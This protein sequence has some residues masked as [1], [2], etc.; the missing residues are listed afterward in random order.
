MAIVL[1]NYTSCF[2][3]VRKNTKTNRK[4]QPTQIIT[5]RKT[6]SKTQRATCLPISSIARRG[7][8]RGLRRKEAMSVECHQHCAG[9]CDTC[10]LQL[11]EFLLHSTKIPPL[12]A[13]IDA[14]IYA[15]SP[16][17]CIDCM[18]CRNLWPQPMDS[19]ARLLFRPRK[20]CQSFV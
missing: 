12:S 18:A 19:D 2:C 13:N 3:L 4:I 5:M 7:K 15:K 10:P 9:S 17:N 11:S 20:N 1:H 16:T 6:T 8:I 14:Y